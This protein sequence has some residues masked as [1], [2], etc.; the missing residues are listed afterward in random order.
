MILSSFIVLCGLIPV[1]ICLAE[2]QEKNRIP[3]NF[4]QAKT[5]IIELI[6]RL[7]DVVKQLYKD[8]VAPI[9]K[10]VGDIAL[11]SLI[12]AKNYVIDVW[13]S[14]I[15]PFTDDIIDKIKIFLG[16]EIEQRKPEVERELEKEKQ[17]IKQEF[18]NEIPEIK[19]TIWQ[20]IKEFID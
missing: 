17:E 20:K 18:K 15:K 4:K 6:I 5:L 3:Q 12:Q 11:N 14:D 16:K 9:F 19:Q 1:Q 13:N 2:N 10:K 7:P 8:D